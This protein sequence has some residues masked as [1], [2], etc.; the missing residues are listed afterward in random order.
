MPVKSSSIRRPREHESTHQ[1][2]LIAPHSPGIPASS[3]A[4]WHLDAQISQLLATKCPHLRALLGAQ[5][6]GSRVDIMRPTVTLS[7]TPG[8]ADSLKMEVVCCQP[9]GGVVAAARDL[10]GARHW[11]AR[12]F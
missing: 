4:L 2:R 11:A 1:A 5:I 12:S 6:G 3:S 7:E 9:S 8:P 10:T